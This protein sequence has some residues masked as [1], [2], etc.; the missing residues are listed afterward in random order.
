MVEK[1][2]KKVVSKKEFEKLLNLFGY[3][4]KQHK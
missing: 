3:E 1:E 4:K 2:F